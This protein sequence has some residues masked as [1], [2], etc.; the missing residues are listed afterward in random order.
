MLSDRTPAGVLSLITY[1]F[2]VRSYKV[3]VP[4]SPT[5]LLSEVASW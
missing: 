2:I 3:M 1:L 4:T 5:K